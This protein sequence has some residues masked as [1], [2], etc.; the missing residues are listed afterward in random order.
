[1]LLSAIGYETTG[2][3]ICHLDEVLGKCLIENASRRHDFGSLGRRASPQERIL[4]SRSRVSVT[5]MEQET[6]SLTSSC[7]VSLALEV[8]DAASNHYRGLL[9]RY[10]DFSCQIILSGVWSNDLTLCGIVRGHSRC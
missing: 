2:R 9:R 5:Q 4:A 1:M 6:C 8:N 3:K 7:S 10:L